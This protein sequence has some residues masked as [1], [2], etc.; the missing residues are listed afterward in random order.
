VLGGGVE[1]VD[2]HTHGLALMKRKLMVLRL[3]HPLDHPCHHVEV[4]GVVEVRTMYSWKQKIT[5]AVAVDPVDRR[6]PTLASLLVGGWWLTSLRNGYE[7][8]CELEEMTW[9]NE[10]QNAYRLSSFG[11][12]SGTKM[13]WKSSTSRK[14]I[15]TRFSLIDDNI[16]FRIM[17]MIVLLCEETRTSSDFA[18]EKYLLLRLLDMQQFPM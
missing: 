14:S 10:F 7:Y 2:H 3:F 13:L 1:K 6:C 5:I 4:G 18:L 8:L 9:L 12:I 11:A 17:K 15:A 16:T